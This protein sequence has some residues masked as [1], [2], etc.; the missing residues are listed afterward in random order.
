MFSQLRKAVEKEAPFTDEEFD[1]FTSLVKVMNLQKD[2]FLFQ[3]GEIDRYLAFVNR[4]CMRYY[5]ID[6]SGDEHTIYFAMEGWWIGD[7]QSFFHELPTP[8]F[9]QALE[10][11]ELYAFSK[12][13]FQKALD[14]IEPYSRF[15]KSVVPKSYAAMQ[16]RFAK[17]QSESAEER[18]LALL[19]KQPQIFQRVPQYLIASYLGIKPQSLSRIRKNFPK[20]I[21]S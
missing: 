5:L 21:I 8:Y 14:E 7:M 10:P 11:C 9:M 19:K 18:Y 4:G 2:E 13:N 12:V 17:T 16:A 3:E 1:R 6:N 20:V 15:F